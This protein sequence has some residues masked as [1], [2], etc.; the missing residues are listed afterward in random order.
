MFG[1]FA[2]RVETASP[3]LDGMGA[4]FQCPVSRHTE[5]RIAD[6]PA[7]AGLSVL[8]TS[9][10][11]GLC[12]VEDRHNRAVCMFNHLEYDT[13]TL[14]AEF[15]RDR[16]AGKPIDVPRHYFPE[17]DPARLP[18]NSWH[19]SARTLFGNWLGEIQRSVWQRRR[20]DALIHWAV[21][22]PRARVCG[23]SDKSEFLVAPAAG[24]DL[25]PRILHAL[26]EDGLAPR[27]F[28]VHRPA[29]GENLVELRT[30]SLSTDAAERM[31][32]RLSELSGILRVAFRTCQGAGGWLAGTHPATPVSDESI[33]RGR[34]A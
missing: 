15:M 23:G 6:L 33:S 24:S 10:E 14:R 26:A 16:E 19:S 34:A 22:M 5:V 25:L 28:K 9:A 30:D 27:A 29:E 13:A 7:G 20:D 11:S 8:A 17:D 4:E 12:L 18:V 3:L 31:A 1:V 21:A 32:Q 2:Q